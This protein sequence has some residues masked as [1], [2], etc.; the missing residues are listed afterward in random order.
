[1]GETTISRSVFCSLHYNTLGFKA[2][3]LKIRA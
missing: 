2:V 1:M 3:V